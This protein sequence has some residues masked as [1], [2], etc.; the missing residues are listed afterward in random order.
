MNKDGLKGYL[1]NLRLENS[2]KNL[3]FDLIDKAPEVDQALLNSIADIL[4]LQADFYDQ[5]AD[6][7]EEEAQEYEA[8]AEE[9]NTLDEEENAERVQALLE[10]QQ[11]LLNDIS[12]KMSEI[13]TRHE[14]DSLKQGA[15]Q[16]PSQP[17]APA[18]T[19]L[20]RP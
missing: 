19:D 8:L 20:N 18:S 10:H 12:Q 15:N 9:L 6:L 3:L 4:D 7:L 14:T 17:T 16:P 5:S 1:E 11:T 13:K 2:L